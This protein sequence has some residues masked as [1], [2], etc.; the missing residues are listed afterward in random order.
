[1]VHEGYGEEDYMATIKLAEKQAG[2][3]TDKMD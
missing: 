3:S 1:V 2:L